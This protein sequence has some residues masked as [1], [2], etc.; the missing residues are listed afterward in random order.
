MEPRSITRGTGNSVRRI[1]QMTPTS[2]PNSIAWGGWRGIRYVDLR[3]RRKAEGLK[4]KVDVQLE[5]IPRAWSMGTACVPSTRPCMIKACRAL[6]LNTRSILARA[7]TY[8]EYQAYTIR[9]ETIHQLIQEFFTLHA[10]YASP[11]CSFIIAR[12]TE[13]YRVLKMTTRRATRWTLRAS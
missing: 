4:G 8:T 12:T 1:R 7:V 10:P 3:S 5:L 2:E 11:L 9:Y 6:V 13:R